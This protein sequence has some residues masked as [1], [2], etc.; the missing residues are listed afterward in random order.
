MGVA[1]EEWELGRIGLVVVHLEGGKCG[2]S[3][4][5]GGVVVGKV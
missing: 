3:G 2:I 4:G 5:D 1:A